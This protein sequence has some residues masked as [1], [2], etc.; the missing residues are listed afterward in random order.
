MLDKRSRL[1]ILACAVSASGIAAMGCACESE[2]EEETPVTIPDVSYSGDGCPEG[3]ATVA[4]NKDRTA[5]TLALDEYVASL[6]SVTTWAEVQKSCQ[7]KVDLDL[8][9]GWRATVATVDHR[10]SVELGSG[11]DAVQ[12][13]EYTP[14]GAVSVVRESRLEGPK[15]E[16]YLRRDTFGR[17][18]SLWSTCTGE[19]SIVLNTEI[20]VAQVEDGAEQ[21]GTI[22]VDSIDVDLHE[23]GGVVAEEC[24]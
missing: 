18:L 16:D 1:M 15:T 8:P 21:L 7:I 5:F 19:R 6:E 3:S 11:V 12:R 2:N 23:D 9:E 13:T 10:G 17:R 20:N 14:G 24:P 4:F 22:T